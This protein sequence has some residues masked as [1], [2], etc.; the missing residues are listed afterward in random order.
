M[1]ENPREGSLGDSHSA[2]NGGKETLG[3]FGL[4]SDSF[5][6]IKESSLTLQAEVI[7]RAGF[8]PCPVSTSLVSLTQTILPT[9]RM[10]I[11][12]CEGGP[13]KSHT[14][15]GCSQL[16][17]KQ[18]HSRILSGSQTLNPRMLFMGNLSGFQG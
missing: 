4:A 10:P 14:G 15:A 6:G 12:V 7:H 2:S 17:G 18:E 11:N 16:A 13:V 3:A 5:S 9:A 8:L 1:P